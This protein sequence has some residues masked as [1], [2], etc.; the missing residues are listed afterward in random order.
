MDAGT[1]NIRALLGFVL[2]GCSSPVLHLSDGADPRAYATTRSGAGPGTEPDD[3]RFKPGICSGE[4]MRPDGRTLT[5]AN[6]IEFLA[7]QQLDVRVERPRSDLIYLN[8]TGAGAATPVRLRVAILKSSAEAGREL[9]EAILQHGPGSWGV[10]RSNLAVLGPIGA[11]PDD[12]VFASKTKLACWG[13]F[14][15]AGRDDTYAVPGG[16]R[17]L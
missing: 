4:D 9:H 1:A 12:L 3:I 5:E 13:M 2:F 15:A 17:E 8:V 10:H 16:Y 14:I 6:I 11:L 7:R